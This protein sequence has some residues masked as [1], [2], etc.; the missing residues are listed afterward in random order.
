MV[1]EPIR[2]K[3]ITE[4]EDLVVDTSLYTR[5]KLNRLPIFSVDL[6][7]MKTQYHRM[8]LLLAIILKE[9]YNAYCQKLKSDSCNENFLCVHVTFGFPNM[10]RNVRALFNLSDS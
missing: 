10:S 5:S 2:I 4:K 7:L 1:F 9:I 3:L 6:D 8:S